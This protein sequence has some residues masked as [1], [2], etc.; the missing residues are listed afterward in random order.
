MQFVVY[1]SET[2]PSI[3]EYDKISKIIDILDSLSRANSNLYINGI[4]QSQQ[5]VVGN[6]DWKC[7]VNFDYED[8]HTFIH[9][10][11]A[12]FNF[13]YNENRCL[14]GDDYIEYVIDFPELKSLFGYMNLPEVYCSE[15]Y[16]D[17]I[18]YEITKISLPLFNL[19]MKEQE[20]GD[21]EE[22]QH[23]ENL[24]LKVFNINSI[25]G[26]P[27][28]DSKFTE[29]ALKITKNFLF[30]LSMKYN[31]NL[32]IVEK[33]IYEIDAEDIVSTL[34]EKLE[35]VKESDL[36]YNH[37]YDA[38][39]VQYYY[40]ASLME[41]SPFKYL[42]YYQVVECIYDEVLMAN[43]IGDIQQ[44][45]NSA[46][47]NTN[48]KS[49]IQKIIDKIKWQ[50]NSKKDE[51]KLKL[52]MDKYFKNNASDDIFLEANKEIIELCKKMK[53]IKDD[54]E[55]KDLQKILKVIYRY[56]CDC[57]H[58][59]RNY[60]ISKIADG[61]SIQDYTKLIRLIAERIILNYR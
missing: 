1:L 35:M 24:S 46:W 50:N 36:Y 55:F 6:D 16:K 15:V 48:D 31:I 39:L 37:E 2:E 61:N 4:H 10:I 45:I 28:T 32:N 26:I 3:D 17:R 5:I 27:Y 57:T 34:Y 54:S 60:P 33:N 58:S 44:L 14:Y 49:D 29:I 47:F 23:H 7:N 42:A 40:Q 19:I 38:D 51:D 20:Y 22:Y 12:F 43:T 41:D 8:L 56:R 9:D 53:I 11:N 21:E 30:K 25:L 52:V 13:K 18:Y 59:N